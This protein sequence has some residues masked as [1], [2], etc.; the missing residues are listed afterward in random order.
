MVKGFFSKFSISRCSI[1]KCSNRKFNK[2]RCSGD[3]LVFMAASLFVGAV[4]V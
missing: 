4:R 3:S 2:D 1:S